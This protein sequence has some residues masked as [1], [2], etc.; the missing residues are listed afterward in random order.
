MMPGEITRYM[1]LN[2][3]EDKQFPI[4]M[5]IRKILAFPSEYLTIQFIKLILR[6][7]KFIMKSQGP[8]YKHYFYL[9]RLY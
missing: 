4:S 3:P 8:M 6:S 2:A 5:F 9:L 7:Q 1:G